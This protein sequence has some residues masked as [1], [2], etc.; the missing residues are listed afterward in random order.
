MLS[1]C[2][3]KAQRR[4]AGADL[5]RCSALHAPCHDARGKTTIIK[6]DP[7]TAYR[8]HRSRQSLCAQVL[9]V[10]TVRHRPPRAIDKPLRFINLR[11]ILPQLS[12]PPPLAGSR[13]PQ[14]PRPGSSRATPSS[15]VTA[16]HGRTVASVRSIASC[17]NVF[18]PAGA[19]RFHLCHQEGPPLHPAQPRHVSDARTHGQRAAVRRR[20]RRVVRPGA[21]RH[22]PAYRNQH[23]RLDPG[24]SHRRSDPPCHLCRST[25]LANDYGA[26]HW[27][28]GR[29]PGDR[30]A[31]THGDR[32]VN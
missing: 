9:R 16:T 24:G 19:Q 5:I 29:E 10:T 3:H 7:Q 32:F 18:S 4:C 21:Q 8:Q 22:R 11:P 23:R 15:V 30:N 1:P 20:H 2:R 17:A 25:A 13:Q 14:R 31:L 28:G 6:P 27:L 12:L 26:D